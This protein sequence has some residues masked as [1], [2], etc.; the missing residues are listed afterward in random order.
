MSIVRTKS[1]EETID[2]V[3]E[4]KQRTFDELRT[5]MA[6][7]GDFPPEYY[8][9]QIHYVPDAP[10]VDR[11]EYILD[12]CRGK[13]VLSLGCSGELQ[14]QV[15]EAAEKS[16]GVDIEDV[17]YPPQ[18][19]FL[20]YD[21]DEIREIKDFWMPGEIDLVLMG[22]VLDPSLLQTLRTSSHHRPQCLRR[23]GLSCSREGV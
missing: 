5:K 7:Y 1:L 13:R 14:R 4:V 23:H 10:V 8:Q 12:H 6:R 22:E 19:G 16:Y 17:E 9:K 18:D 15:N 3:S 2:K 21:L 11:L 20:R